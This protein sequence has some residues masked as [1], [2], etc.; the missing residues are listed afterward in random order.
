MGGL[1]SSL[2]GAASAA[3]PSLVTYASKMMWDPLHRKLHFAGC[4]HTGGQTMANAGGLITWDDETNQWSK[5]SYS[6]SSSGPGHSYYHTTVNPSTGDLFYREFESARIL[7]RNYGST[8]Q[9][10]WRS[11]LVANH[12]HA[13]NQAAGG[14]EWFPELNN[15]AGGLVF[16]DARGAARSNAALS[17]WTQGSTAVSGNYHNWSAQA[18]GY[19]YFGGG[20]GSS[21]MYRMNASGVTSSVPNTPLEAGVNAGNSSMVYAHP[22]R[23][24]LLLV[25]R[26]SSGAFHRFNGSSWSSLGSHQVNGTPFV[27]TA[28]PEYGVVLFLVHP[29]GTGTPYL[30]VYKA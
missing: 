26:A 30:R 27:A 14:L 20:N 23:N 28:V 5:E 4:S 2:V 15:G 10:G 8:G 3:V 6:W 7:K 16:V 9:A 12:P 29:G 21:A 24:D 1:T 13:A 17:S 22:N 25:A 18:G 19:V 11:G